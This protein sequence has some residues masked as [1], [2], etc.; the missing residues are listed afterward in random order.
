MKEKSRKSIPKVDIPINFLPSAPVK[1]LEPKKTPYVDS[2]P[3]N[4]PLLNFQHEKSVIS[5]SEIEHEEGEW[6]YEYYDE[7]EYDPETQKEEVKDPKAA[8]KEVTRLKRKVSKE[9]TISGKKDTL[10]EDIVPIKT[11][12]KNR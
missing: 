12:L 10:E 7:E 2:S 1:K 4:T 11:E 3:D 6:E 9:V 8:K 5:P